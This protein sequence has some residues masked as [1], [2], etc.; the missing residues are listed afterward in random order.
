MEDGADRWK[1]RGLEAGRQEGEV[2]A[3]RAGAARALLD[4]HLDGAGVARGVRH[5][6]AL[7]V[8][9]LPAQLHA[10]HAKPDL[11]GGYRD[12]KDRRPNRRGTGEVVERMAVV[13]SAIAINEALGFLK[14]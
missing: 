9:A 2:S 10:D 4:D 11:L 3:R 5:V 1:G 6:V 13:C 8:V 14:D 12:S 7:G